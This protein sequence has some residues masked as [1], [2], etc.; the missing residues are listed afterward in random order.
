[1]ETRK[2]LS[3]VVPWF[4][5]PDG[6]GESLLG[7]EFEQKWWSYL[8]SQVCQHS[9][10]TSSLQAVFGYGELWHRIDCGCRRKPE[11]F[12]QDKVTLCVYWLVLCQLD[13]AGVI[14][15]KGPSVEEMPP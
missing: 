11:C 4:L 12:F 3:L 15:E 5:S 9:W 2:I 10:V 1:M 7:Q 8:Y 13:T 14:T 6:S